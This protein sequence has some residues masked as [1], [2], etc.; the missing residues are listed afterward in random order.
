MSNLF[1]SSNYSEYNSGDYN[2]NASFELTSNEFPI[3]N[4]KIQSDDETQVNLSE[5]YFLLVNHNF[6]TGEELKYTWNQEITNTPIG[7]ATTT[8]S[9]IST[10]ILPETVY[11][12]KLDDFKIQVS[13]SKTE[14]LLESPKILDLTNY[15][16]GEHVLAATNQNKNSIISINNLIQS[17]LVST[18]ST[19]HT[20]ESITSGDLSVTVYSPNIFSGGDLIKIDDEILRITS[21]GIGSTNSIEFIREILGT[22]AETH[23]T[24]SV[25][26]KV[27]GNYNIVDNII[28]FSS[29]P[30]GE[31]YDE[32]NGLSVKSTFSGRIF[33]RSGI[34]N[35]DTGPYDKNYIFD[36]I[37][38]QFTG[39]QTSFVL[40]SNNQNIEGIYEDNAVILLN[41]VFQI[42]SRLTGSTIENSYVIEENS[43]ISSVR[44]TGNQDF[45]TYDVNLSELPRGGILFSIGSN[46]GLGYQPLISAGGTAVVSSAGTI[47]SI[48][49]GYSGSGYRE[50]LQNVRVG[51]AL[52]DVVDTNIEYVGV[53]S[54]SNGRVV[55]VSVTN[56][57]IGYTTTN[58]PIVVID[59]PLPYSNIPLIYSS[60]S[61]GI[62][63]E[64]TVDIVVGQG[65]SII[66]F[67]INN[68]GYSY[69][70]G[71]LLTVSIGGTIGIP[72]TG[73]SN[74]EEFTILVDK[75]YNDSFS[76]WSI[77]QLVLID[78]LDDLFDGQRTVFPIKINGEQTAILSRVGSNLDV[79]N[80]LLV[81]IDNI[82][83]VPGEA[84][85]F[86]GGSIIEFSEPPY[87]G[88][89]G[90]ILF[91]GGTAN[92]DT[93]FT[94]ILQTIKI[95]DTVKIYDNTDRFYDQDKRTVSDIISADV[96]RTNLYSK[97]GISIENEERPISWWI[98]TEDKFITGSGSTT[99]SATAKDREIY[100]SLI[101]PSSYVIKTVQPSDKEIFVD[102]VKTFFD[103]QKEPVTTYDAFIISD[104]ESEIITDVSYEGDFGHITGIATTSVGVVFDFY[105]P[106]D[107]FIKDSEINA[108]S[109]S[110]GISGIQTGY[111]FYISNS[112]ITNGI[113]SLD[114]SDNAIGIG[115][116][117]FDNVY[118]VYSVSTK[119]KLVPGIGSTDVREVVTKVSNNSS[120]VGYGNSGYYGNFSWG[121]VYK[122][123]RVGIN[124]F[125]S[126]APGISTST[127]LIRNNPLKYFNYN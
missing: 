59:S 80:N 12:V 119:Q 51:V 26:T 101:Y 6:V 8:I 19:T 1:L 47:Q 126:Y 54:V 106:Q 91:Y 34:K 36:D 27:K 87:A 90:T 68:L 102:N 30:Y 3:F 38:P 46:E 55:G 96:I 17:P 97:Q 13:A 33:L 92:V 67:K 104:T 56:P 44:F 109:S 75:I 99:F 113:T 66:D 65:S 78:P 85:Y 127:V 89:K 93:E 108:S 74:F 45:Q 69:S 42:P 118:Q 79:Q 24:N 105:I 121:R 81:F 124:T 18:Y 32:N 64:A 73:S 112:N 9:G 84:Y 5:D 10:D 53:A 72:T 120:F 98:Q 29:P 39:I 86:D 77:G 49:I 100:E 21:V 28:Y 52:S 14:S 123:E 70:I 11:A 122:E 76:G 4:K 94:D 82:L 110:N 15:G 114:E 111:Y 115:T 41:E 37:S 71:D 20:L 95:G 107:S 116:T 23:N 43:G 22:T 48:S 62:G 2:S 50:G 60:S 63:T 58:P 117:F 31:V 103:N 83:Q 57:G 35:T 25:V 40:T 61:S 7:I 88:A 16:E 125:Y